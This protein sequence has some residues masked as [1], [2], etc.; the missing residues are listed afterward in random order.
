MSQVPATVCNSFPLS[1]RNAL[2]KHIHLGKSRHQAFSQRHHWWGG[3]QKCF[4]AAILKHSDCGTCSTEVAVLPSQQS[5]F[6]SCEIQRRSCETPPHA[7][8][9][10][11]SSRK[12]ESK[13]LTHWSKCHKV[14]FCTLLLLVHC[15]VSSTQISSW[16]IVGVQRI[17]VDRL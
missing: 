6:S 9:Q 16:R 12:T 10:P 4:R 3:R 13:S 15:P 7:A 1:K 14:S 11:A 2:I 5:S 8:G 17:Y